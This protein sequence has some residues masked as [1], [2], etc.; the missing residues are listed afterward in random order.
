[1]TP[2]AQF[3]Q[4]V[5]GLLDEIIQTQQ[6]A[7]QKGARMMADRIAAGRLIYCIGP[8]GHSQLAV[9]EMF[10]RAGGL[11]NIYPLL[12]T[13]LHGPARAILDRTPGYMDKMVK[14]H[15]FS[16]GD[17]LLVLTAYGINAITIDACLAAQELG[18]EVL[19]VTSKSYA[20]IPPGDRSRHPSNKNLFELADHYIDCLMPY[21]DA[22]LDLPGVDLKV[23]PVST[24]LL[25]FCVECLVAE[26]VQE[27]VNR[28][29]EPEIWLSGNVPNGDERN[30]Y[31]MDKYSH[32]IKDL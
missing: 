19:A 31:L 7:L 15:G 16:E 11:A 27:L 8:G 22:A 18:G 5:S 1:M 32:R 29:L 28:G 12:V 25:F 13:Y 3:H 24:I 23:S 30:Q 17:L 21:G 6:A 4:K 20:G 2:S 9:E 14:L 26:T 10:H